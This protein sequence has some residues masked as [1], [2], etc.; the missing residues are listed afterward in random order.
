[1]SYRNEIGHTLRDAR[2]AAGLTLRDVAAKIRIKPVYLEAIEAG[3]FERL[4]A[5]PQTVG[6][7]RSYAQL[8]AVDVDAPLARLGEEVHR[9]IEKTDYS[10]PELPWAEVSMSRIVWVVAGAALGMVLLATMIFDFGAPLDEVPPMA[11][12][13]LERLASRAAPIAPVVAPVAPATAPPVEEAAVAANSSVSGAPPVTVEMAALLNGLAAEDAVIAEAVA[14]VSSAGPQLFALRDVHLRAAPANAGNVIG[15]LSACEAL[16]FIGSDA[17]NPWRQ[18]QRA[19]GAT[20][21]VY[22]R[23]I[24]DSAP[25]SCR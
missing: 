8:L 22:H 14:P 15:V 18:V 17:A 7:T 5:L 21:W 25:A 23:Y 16:A 4:P 2:Q 6:F 11:E 12:V 1:M 24:A 3:Q 20:G 10:A 19:D 13:P 9:D